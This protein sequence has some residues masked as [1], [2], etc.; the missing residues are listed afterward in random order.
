MSEGGGDVL[1][2]VQHRRVFTLFLLIPILPQ[3][4]LIGIHPSVFVISNNGG[5]KPKDFRYNFMCG[6]R[7]GSKPHTLISYHSN[8]KDSNTFRFEFVMSSYISITKCSKTLKMNEKVK[9]NELTPHNY[10][11]VRLVNCIFIEIISKIRIV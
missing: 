11:I 3:F 6:K 10:F 2:F 7:C 9:I 4:Y 8:S 5:L 1:F